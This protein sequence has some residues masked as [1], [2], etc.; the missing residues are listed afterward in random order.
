LW[1]ERVVVW[2]EAVGTAGLAS[3]LS[4]SPA[5]DVVWA[6][7]EQATRLL[8]DEIPSHGSV[9]LH[10][11]RLKGRFL[12][13]C[14]GTKRYICCGYRVLRV[15]ENCNLG[16][17]Y[18]VL[19]HYFGTSSV[20]AHVNWSQ[21][22]EELSVELAARRFTRVGTGEFTDSLS[23]DHVVGLAPKLVRFF[24]GEEHAVLELKTKCASV[25]QL[26]GADPKRGTLVSW[27]LNSPEIVAATEGSAASLEDRLRA[28]SQVVQWGYG[29]GF[30]FDPLVWYPGWQE[31]YRKVVEMLFEHVGPSSVVWISLGALR[32]PRWVGRNS[33]AS[34]LRD[35]TAH[36]E[37]V[38]G[39]DGKARYYAP[40]RVELF[41][42]VVSAIREIA[43][44]ELPL[45]LCME[46]R[47]VWRES[48]GWGPSGSQEVA[49]L[50]DGAAIRHR[51]GESI[52]PT[53]AP[54]RASSAADRGCAQSRNQDT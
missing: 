4:R 6:D 35:L 18:C 53:E 45:Y 34:R 38:T 25:R 44:G 46:S 52:T 27:S 3:A 39:L 50:L 7:V 12:V 21:M 9:S 20:V 13:P 54:G 36:G 30:H 19:P 41:R 22:W 1:P 49:A 2:P 24:S 42:S 37:W 29:V 43:G 14:P 26:R 11:K 51:R 47:R 16:C 28:A 48:L 15:G 23:W 33:A 32:F 8:D 5:C 40:M 31:D 10:L 17:S